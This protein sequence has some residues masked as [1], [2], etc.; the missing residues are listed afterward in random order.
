MPIYEFQCGS[1]GTRIERI[2]KPGEVPRPSCPSCRKR[3][4]RLISPT[5]F[6]LKGEGW[7]VTDYPSLERR[8]AMAAEKE[9]GGAAKEPAPAAK[10]EKPEKPGKP[11]KP[12]APAKA[13]P[14]RGKGR[15]G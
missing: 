15:K 1:C 11:G 12:A 3:M 2:F 13:A 5:A 6:I 10:P 8:K 14:E 9:K 4:R 7:Y